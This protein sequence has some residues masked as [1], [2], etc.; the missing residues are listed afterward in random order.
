MNTKNAETQS[1]A[2]LRNW[3]LDEKITQAAA[4]D[5]IGISRP[6]FAKALHFDPGA[7]SLHGD[8]L[9][10]IESKTGAPVGGWL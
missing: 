9:R 8:I 4:A 6:T 3:F 2:V 7:D 5:L 1:R 10:K